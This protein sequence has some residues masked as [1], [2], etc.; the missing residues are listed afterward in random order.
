MVRPISTYWP[1]NER[2]LLSGSLAGLFVFHAVALFLF[3]GMALLSNAFSAAVP[4]VAGLCC[5]WR[6]AQL[7]QRERPGWI[8][9][10]VGFFLWAA[11]QAAFSCLTGSSWNLSPSADISDLLF[12]DAG[13]PFFLAIA[14]T[15][16]SQSRRGVLYINLFQALIATVLTYVRLFKISMPADLAAATTYEIYWGE[17]LLLAIGSTLRLLTWST[18]EERRRTR[19]LCAMLWMYLPIELAL[20]YP[21]ASWQAPAG[22]LVATV[23]RLPK[24]GFFELLWSLPFL[25]VGWQALRLPRDN[26][27]IVRAQVLSN[28]RALLLRS[29]FPLL[30]TGALFG[31][32]VSVA[33]HYFY[34]GVAAMLL[35][36]IV[37]GVHSGVL[38]V[39]YLMGHANLLSKEKE[40][41]ATNQELERQSTLDPLTGIP[42]RRFFAHAFEA[43]WK[44]ALRKNEPLSL[45][46]IDVDYFK[47]VNDAHGHPYGDECLVRIAKALRQEL[48]RGV[49]VVARY[50]GEEFIVL[51]PD[52]D[53][54]GA[55][56]VAA[57]LQGA[58]AELNI[59][60]RASPLGHQLTVS[61]G[62]A[63]CY[64]STS[65]TCGELIARAD[66]ALYRAKRRGRNRICWHSEEDVASESP[67]NVDKVR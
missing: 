42:N 47:R 43:E 16:D 15:Y 53:L 18:A 21:S 58:I 13:I 37:Q 20:D 38:Q 54:E 22:T 19:T 66:R 35:L 29:L 64:P 12:F 45:L 24:G 51:L 48:Q 7:R 56:T 55:G 14:N 50:G 32:A 61:I 34:F 30:V 25:F 6:I 26:E 67:Q 4:F 65:L 3:P 57:G 17:C 36:L 41:K 31:M 60:N 62:I 44:R 49:D 11:A 28:R 63:D 46:M 33:Q 1:L 23:W 2:T 39:N 10:A 52:T 9:I 59:V 5:L 40:L 8:W 27:G